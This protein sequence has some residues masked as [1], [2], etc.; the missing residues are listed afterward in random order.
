VHHVVREPSDPLERIRRVQVTGDR[1]HRA[2]TQQLLP[3]RRVR[4]RVHPVATRLAE[5]QPA[6]NVPVTQDQRLIPRRF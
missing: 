3:R 4:Q 5:N 2:G 1:H 6:A